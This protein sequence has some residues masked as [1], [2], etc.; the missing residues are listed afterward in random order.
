MYIQTFKGWCGV[1]YYEREDSRYE[2][3]VGQQRGGR[4]HSII[5]GEF[6]E[7]IELDIESMKYE[8]IDVPEIEECKKATILHDFEQ[9]CLH[10]L[11]TN[12]HSSRVKYVIKQRVIMQ[13][14]CG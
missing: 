4:H 13:K 9:V 8:R 5:R 7:Q 14:P 2:N 12:S 3:L 1:R 6:E 10:W 11:N